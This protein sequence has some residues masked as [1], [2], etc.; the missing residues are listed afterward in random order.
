MGPNARFNPVEGRKVSSP[1]QEF[2][3]EFVAV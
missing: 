1:G 3:P 2:N